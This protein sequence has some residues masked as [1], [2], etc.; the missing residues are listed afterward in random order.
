M[1][2]FGG[3]WII[4]GILGAGMMSDGS[5]LVKD[6]IATLFG[7]VFGPFVLGLAIRDMVRP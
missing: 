2:T 1:I 3:I 6:V 5:S 4:S 7:L